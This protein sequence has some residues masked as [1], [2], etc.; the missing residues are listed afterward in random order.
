MSEERKNN[1]TVQRKWTPEEVQFLT[2]AYPNKDF[3][4]E[5]IV[6][7]LDRTLISVK[8]K[9]TRLHLKRPKDNVPE[10]FKRC[11]GCQS[12]LPRRLFHRQRS[13]ADGLRSQ[14]VYCRQKAENIVENKRENTLSNSTCF[15][16]HSPTSS[17]VCKKCGE[18]K[19]LSEF[20]KWGNTKDGLRGACIECLR[21]QH[22]HYRVLGGYQYDRD[23]E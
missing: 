5:E 6:T 22:R 18:I 16:Y 15:S 7:A 9:A 1:G 23:S 3:T 12:I 20:Y 17:K 11:S 13:K 21:K 19:P 8:S 2:F 4:I 10:G 14:C